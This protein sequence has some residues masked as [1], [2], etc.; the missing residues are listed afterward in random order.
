MGRQ[1]IYICDDGPIAEM[2][3]FVISESTDN[4][5]F[6][7]TRSAQVFEYIEKERPTILIVDLN[8]PKVS[9]DSLISKIRKNDRL[10]AMGII[11]ISA[12]FN[13]KEKAMA[14]GADIFLAKPFNLNEILDAITRLSA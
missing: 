6:S 3:C 4:E 11:C 12:E 13:A 10:S 8:M 9:G 14:A 7:E 1:K 2:L 5:V